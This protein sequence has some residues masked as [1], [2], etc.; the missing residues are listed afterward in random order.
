MFFPLRVHQADV[1]V[2]AAAGP[3]R[4]RLCHEARG[5]PVL[6][7]DRLH[8][9][10]QQHAVV[11]GKLGARDMVQ[12]DLELARG[13]FLERRTGGDVLRLAGREEVREKRIGVLDVFHA[14]VLR[15]GLDLPC[16]GNESDFRCRPLGVRLQQVEL[17]L[18][19]GRPP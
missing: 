1:H 6:A 11:R 18:G 13:E 3:F 4:E 2:H 15:T 12:V 9:A 16:A 14:A 17:E 7:R 19:R 5:H 10:L 8:G